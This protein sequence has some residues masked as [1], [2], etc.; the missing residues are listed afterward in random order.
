[1]QEIKYKKDDNNNDDG[2]KIINNWETKNQQP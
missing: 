1:M 2:K